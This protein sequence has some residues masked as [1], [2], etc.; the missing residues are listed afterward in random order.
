MRNSRLLGALYL[1]RGSLRCA[2]RLP[3]ERFRLSVKGKAMD[4]FREATVR[5]RAAPHVQA[6]GE[7]VEIHGPEEDA[8]VTLRSWISNLNPCS[9]RGCMDG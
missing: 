2:G 8:R 7:T 9:G 4:F 5:D 3:E 1:S 6:L